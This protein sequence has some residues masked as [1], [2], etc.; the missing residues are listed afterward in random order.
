MQD[1][2]QDLDMYTTDPDARMKTAHSITSEVVLPV[3]YS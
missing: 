1:Y 3:K 2:C